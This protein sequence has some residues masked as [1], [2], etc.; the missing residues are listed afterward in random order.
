[1]TTGQRAQGT[2][3]CEEEHAQPS[4]APGWQ[5]GRLYVVATPIGNLGDLAP[6]AL[7]VLGAVR[8]V[9]A[10]DTRRVRKLLTHFGV[11]GAVRSL[12]EH[13]EEREVP[14]LL[15]VLAG[16]SDLALVSDAGTPLLADPGFRLVRACRER[17]IPVL[18]VPGASAVTAALAVSGLPPTP[19]TFAGFLSP[20][21]GARAAALAALAAL[22]HTLVLFCSPHRLAQELSACSAGLGAQREAVLLAELTKVHERC[23]RGSLAELAAWASAAQPRGEYTLVVGP[24]PPPEASTPSPLAARAAVDAARA[25]GMARPQALKEAAQQLGVSRRVLYELLTRRPD[26]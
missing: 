12:H 17:D 26:R 1:M 11:S 19:F 15:A 23:A 2:G 25:R 24:P 3:H 22:P 14:R 10:E 5:G 8:W 4:R 16:G 18:A 13:N 9:L 7:E 6:R 21:E 20:R